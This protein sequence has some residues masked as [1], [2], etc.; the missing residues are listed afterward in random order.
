MTDKRK[1][2][3]EKVVSFRVDSK[4]FEEMEKLSKL[5]GSGTAHAFAREHTEKALRT[6]GAVD[7]WGKDEKTE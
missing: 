1:K 7:S 5:T 2:N 6:V 4:S 3:K